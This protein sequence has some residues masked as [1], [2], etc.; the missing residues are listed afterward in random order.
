MLPKIS[1][2]EELL[3]L[4]EGKTIAIVGPAPYLLKH[5]KGGEIDEHDIIVRLNDFIPLKKIRK[6]YGTR[7]DIVFSN[8]GTP[9]M[10]GITE[11]LKIEDT[12]EYFKK[13]KLVVASAIKSDHSESNFL[14]F[15][16]NKVT[17]VVENFQNINKYN[18][19]FYWIGIKD[20]KILYEKIGVEFNTGVASICILL[21]YP[22]KK[23]SLYGF[24]FYKGGNTYKDIYCDGH[25]DEEDQKSNNMIFGFYSGHGHY[26]NQKQFDFLLELFKNYSI[27]L[28]EEEKEYLYT[29]EKK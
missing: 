7:T 19:P 16:E 6:H 8:F 18:I 29:K 24:S 17:K 27:E 2:N 21:Q 11:K 5:Q 28:D 9:W 23:L 1:I 22:I 3:K 4:V 14:N 15:D 10:R 20:Y 12:D 26:A 13:I 25:M